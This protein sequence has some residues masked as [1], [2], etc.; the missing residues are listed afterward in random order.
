MASPSR[1]RLR[2]SRSSRGVSTHSRQVIA[3]S[4]AVEPAPTPSTTSTSQGST[5]CSSAYVERP[6]S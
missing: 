2:A 4:Y 5:S 6:Q 1:A 3:S